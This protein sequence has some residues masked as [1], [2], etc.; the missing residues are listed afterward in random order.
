MRELQEMKARVSERPYLFE[1]VKQVGTNKVNVHYTVQ[2]TCSSSGV[3]MFFYWQRNA[4]ARAEQAYRSKLQKAG[5]EEKFVEETG[6]SFRSED[7][8]ESR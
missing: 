7:D 6:V 1:Q 2:V 3:I 4:K 8:S 5:L